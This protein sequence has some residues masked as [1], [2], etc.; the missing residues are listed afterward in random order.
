MSL[1]LGEAE[2]AEQFGL[3]R[4]LD[5]FGDHRHILLPGNFM[6]TLSRLLDGR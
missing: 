2:A 1:G 6:M 4:G 3:F 5:P